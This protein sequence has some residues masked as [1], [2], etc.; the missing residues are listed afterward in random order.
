MIHC[1]HAETSSYMCV[2]GFPKLPKLAKWV[3][4]PEDSLYI[5]KTPKERM[6]SD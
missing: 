5:F 2:D 3:M 1:L 6:D 4:S